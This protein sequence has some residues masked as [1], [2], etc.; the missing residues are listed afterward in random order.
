MALRVLMKPENQGL[1][2][3]MQTSCGGVEKRDGHAP[4][5]ACGGFF[6]VGVSGGFRFARVAVTE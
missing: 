5:P 4:D 1:H 6:V 2:L 3:P